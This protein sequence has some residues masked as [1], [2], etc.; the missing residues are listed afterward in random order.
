[1]GTGVGLL[2]NQL[3]PK[4]F[5]HIGWRYYAV[6]VACDAVAACSFFMF[7]PETKGKTLEEIAELFGDDLAFTEYVGARGLYVDQGPDKPHAR[8]MEQDAQHVEGGQGK[9][10]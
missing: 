7:Y 5:A 3:S 10:L 8:G 9:E 1:M 2:F 6:F 4:A